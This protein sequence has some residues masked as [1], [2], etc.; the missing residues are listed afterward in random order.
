[1][2]LL[3]NG[4]KILEAGIGRRYWL[5]PYRKMAA[6][7]TW[8]YHFCD[9]GNFGDSEPDFIRMAGE[10]QID[11][12]HSDFDAVISQQTIEHVRNPFRLAV[13]LVRVIKPGGLL[14]LVAPVTWGTRHHKNPLDCFR[15]LPDG[16]KAIIEESGCKCLM[17]MME[18]MKVDTYAERL[19]QFGG[20]EVIDCIGI[21]QKA[22]DL[23]I[24]IGFRND[25]TQISHCFSNATS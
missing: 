14:V 21:G 24:A 25:S 18:N 2:P 9:L 4:I 1:M 11:Y 23:G 3:K 20:S 7:K 12:P 17:A 15:I 5:S 6:E 19:C 16:M 10:Y 22:E 8:D 13:E